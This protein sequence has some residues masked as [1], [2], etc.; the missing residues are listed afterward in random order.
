MAIDAANGSEVWHADTDGQQPTTASPAIDPNRQ[1][2]YS[3]GVD[4][5]AHKYRV[6]DGTEITA[7]AGRRRSRSRPT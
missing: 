1:Y 7:A 3:Y 2:V 4:G 5:N 6:G